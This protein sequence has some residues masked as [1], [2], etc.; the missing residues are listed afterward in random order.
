MIERVDGLERPRILLLSHPLTT[1]TPAYGGGPGLEVER[2]T[3]I[4]RGDTANT[5]RISFPNHLGTHVD[6]PSHFFDGAPTLTDYATGQWV[7]SHPCIVDVGTNR[8]GL[9]SVGDVAAGI[10][11]QADLVLVRTGHGTV[12]GSEDYWRG[13]PGL[14][15]ELGTWLREE[16][17]SVRAVGMDLISVTSRLH[18]EA[19]RAAHRAFLDPGGPGTPIRLIEDMDLLNCPATL[20]W[21]LC[22]PL[23]LRDADGGPVT[24]WAMAAAR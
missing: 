5:R 15:A 8:D 23:V 4:E 18:R 13:G 1:D 22:S 10:P 21:V 24:V 12:R 6:C 7:F 11:M 17:P 20:E 2:I 14:S 16:R 3:A 19:G 9:V